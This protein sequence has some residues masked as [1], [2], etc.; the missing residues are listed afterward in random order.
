MSVVVGAASGR[1]QVADDHSTATAIAQELELDPVRAPITAAVVARAKEALERATRLRGAGD[2]AHA[3]AADGLAR[4][5]A[6][7]ARDLAR[8]ADAEAQASDSRRK[9]V[10]AQA[11]LVRARALV[12]EGIARVGRLRAQLDEASRAAPKDRT[13]VETHGGDPTPS[14]SP[15]P[16]AK[17]ADSKDKPTKRS[18]SGDAP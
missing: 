11:R 12:E 7:T 10:D 6:E 3:K 5:W 18:S 13:A 1:A 15:G 8:A 2:E 16:T 14:L 17:K 9:A 4:E